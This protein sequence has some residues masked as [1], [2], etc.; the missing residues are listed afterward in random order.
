VG[1]AVCR[2]SAEARSKAAGLSILIRRGVPSMKAGAR[3]RD[4][5]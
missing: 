5:R 3:R 1:E 2:S 4:A